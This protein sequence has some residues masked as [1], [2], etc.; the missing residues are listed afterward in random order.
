MFALGTAPAASAGG[1]GSWTRLTPPTQANIA[2]PGYARTDD[3]VLQVLWIA[4]NAQEPAHQDLFR[5]AIT[6][7]GTLLGSTAVETNWVALSAPALVAEADGLH[8]DA[9][10][11][12]Q[13]TT[14]ANEK[15]NGLNLSVSEDRGEQWQLIPGTRA[16][17]PGLTSSP[18]SA[19]RLG[20]VFWQAWGGSGYGAFTH[21]GTTPASP[22]VNLQERI[23][24]G[25]C[26]YEPNIV[27]DQV[28][29]LVQVVWYSNSTDATGVWTQALHS[30][31]G[32]PVRD[33]E[34]MPG[35]EAASQLSDRVPFVALPTGGFFAAYP[36]DDKVLVWRIGTAASR[37]VGSNVASLAGTTIAA[38][39]DNRLWLAW[40]ANV[41]GVRRVVARRSNPGATKFGQVV[42]V[43]PPPGTS[44]FWSLYGEGNPDGVLDALALVTT[45]A[46]IATWHSQL[47]PGLTVSAIPAAIKR[48]KK[49]NVQFKVTDA[50]DP[51]KGAKVKVGG[52]SGKTG[53]GGTVKIKLGKFKKAGH[54]TAFATLDGYAQGK[55]GV[56][57]KK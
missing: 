20:D 1:P 49:T 38:T 24:G 11:G 3:D 23:G 21:R 46:G 55:T 56:K 30:A 31:T 10:F 32:D 27:A 14:A 18:M 43:K 19:T 54:L 7:N 40:S 42:T 6:K 26:G 35:T 17:G 51:V 22:A 28:N 5:S 41:A 4:P 13:R 9:F 8:L 52:K 39:S 33:P 25:C 50:G 2:E 48:S 15:N 12:G 53:A 57:I 34:R 37:K 44:T 47:E 36:A 45:P 29:G 16:D